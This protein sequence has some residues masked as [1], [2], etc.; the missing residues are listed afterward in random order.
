M[1]QNEVTLGRF[2]RIVLLVVGCLVAFFVLDSLSSV[3]LPFA[4]AWL[5]AYLMNPLVNFV[6]WKLRFRYRALSIFVSLLLV[7]LLIYGVVVLVLPMVFSEL[8]A[9]KD[10]TVSFLEKNFSDA[11]IPE[12]IMNLFEG[13][14]DEY[15]FTDKLKNSGDAGLLDVIAKEAQE[16]LLGTGK[17]AG[18]V[19][20]LSIIVLYLFF[21]LLDFERVS[22]GWQPYVP[23]KWRGIVLKLWSDLVYGMNQYFRGQALVALCVGILFSIGFV[24]IDFPAAIAFGLFIGVL[25]LVPYLQII[26]L[27][28]MAL[29]AMLKAANTGGDFWPIMIMALVV[30][31]V[32]Q[33]IQDLI[34]V[35]RIMGKRM[36]LHPAIILLS[37]SIWG[38]L[39]GMLGMIV[40]LP[41]TTLLLAYLKRYNE[42]AETSNHAEEIILK[43]AI[44]SARVDKRNVED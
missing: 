8:Y 10:I 42:I 40:A 12:P 11:S 7:A 37:L 43:E 34:L 24:L 20:S 35:P 3:L 30:M 16:V 25:N 39:L 13:I 44:G 32:V 33:L 23:K 38:H 22:R 21:I 36:N 18:Q 41:L 6:Q 31:L 17:L 15:G 5:L 27:L 14:S 29:L 9:L 4:I 28:P 19:L 2:L 1:K 26:S